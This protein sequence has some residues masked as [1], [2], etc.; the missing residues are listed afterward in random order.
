MYTDILLKLTPIFR[1]VL[2]DDTIIIASSTTA[3]DVEGW[4]SLSH[5]R[6]VLTVEQSFKV[7]FSAR[8]V[9]SLKNVGEFVAL[10]QSK[11]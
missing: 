2:D 5:I 7:K 9:N 8:E 4:D 11:L 6:L 1:D 3:E 10:I